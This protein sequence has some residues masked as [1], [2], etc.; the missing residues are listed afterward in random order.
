MSF[1]REQPAPENARAMALRRQIAQSAT[2]WQPPEDE[3]GVLVPMAPVVLLR[4]DDLLLAASG[5][6]AFSNGFL[7]RVSVVARKPEA[8]VQRGPTF[9]PMGG[10]GS[11][12]CGVQYSDGRRG[13]TAGPPDPSAIRDA[14]NRILIMP[15]GGHGGPRR[16]DK[17]VWIHPLPPTGPITFVAKWSEVGHEV[18]AQPILVAAAESSPMWPRVTPVEAPAPEDLEAVLLG[19]L[20]HQLAAIEGVRIRGVL[21][22]GHHP[23]T[24]LVIA[25][26]TL[27]PQRVSGEVRVAVWDEND[28]DLAHRPPIEIG[29][30]IVSRL[31]EAF[32]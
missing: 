21:L 22:D 1:F 19:A 13:D 15:R 8:L 7:L 24:N 5:F 18:D 12:L 30:M 16:L 31:R 3:L 4:N 26:D 6:E 23:D 28:A 9:H 14:A 29:A 20:T 11:V 32:S 17:S 27:S 2:V 10:P 25:Y